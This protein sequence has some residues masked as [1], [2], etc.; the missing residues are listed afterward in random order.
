MQ[1]ILVCVLMES[2]CSAFDLTMA[3]DIAVKCA[4]Y[5]DKFIIRLVEG[6]E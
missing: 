1:H 6:H 5:W 2:A 4:K 3:N